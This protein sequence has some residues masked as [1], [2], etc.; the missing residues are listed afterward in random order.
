MRSAA[1]RRLELALATARAWRRRGLPRGALLA[2]AALFVA[3]LFLAVLDWAKLSTV[4]GPESVA[5]QAFV[6]LVLGG[7]LIHFVAARERLARR[8]RRYFDLSR[9]LLCTANFDGYFEWVNPA[10]EETLG[11]T[12]E[13]L[14]SRPFAEFVHPDER[15]DT[16]GE[17]GRLIGEQPET[18]QFR[19]RYRTADGSYRWLEWNTRVVAAE[20]RFYAA[21]RDIT[22]Q[23][24]A[25]E[26]LDNQATRLEV[27]VRKRTMA[28][29]ESRLETLQR[30]ALAAEYRDD[31]THEHTER[32]GRNAA[33]VA[34]Q[35]GLPAEIVALV[36]QAAPLH[37]IGKV[38]IPDAIL[39]KLGGLTPA[40]HRQM[41]E[42]TLIGARILANPRFAI[43]RMAESIALTHHEHW[44]GRG[45]PQG[46]REKEIPLSGRIVAVADVFDALTHERPYKSAWPA[47]KAVEEIQRLA[48][49]QFEPRV[50]KAFASLDHERMLEPI[51]AYD[52]DLPAP[53]LVLVDE[54]PTR[55][56]ISRR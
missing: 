21:A 48:G 36:R 32:V 2:I 43:L 51:A 17:T 19:N 46:L 5:V 42:H 23:K 20:R 7:A 49:R 35:L 3:A 14:V 26:A 29:E 37:D 44:N 55:P 39:F 53:P 54:M 34:L 31:A 45:Y 33:L 1:W 56:E 27:M 12:R 50:V 16:Q 10:W 9:D 4:L 22:A 30:L 38:G 52:L 15:A 6:L 8:S 13:E 41:Q 24:E 47:E 25:E 40:E 11:F 18:H 28:L